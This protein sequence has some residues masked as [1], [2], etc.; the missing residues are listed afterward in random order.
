MCI[1]GPDGRTQVSILNIDKAIRPGPGI[2]FLI[3]QFEAITTSPEI[4]F[5]AT[6]IPSFSY[7]GDL[8]SDLLMFL[9]LFLGSLIRGAIFRLLRLFRTVRTFRVLK[10]FRLI[11]ELTTR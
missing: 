1:V 6:L 10:Q 7:C 9:S 4:T 3:N 2:Q 8:N 11:E 5:G